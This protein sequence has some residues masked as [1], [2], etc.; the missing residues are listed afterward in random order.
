MLDMLFDPNASDVDIG[1]DDYDDI[2]AK[3]KALENE[4][5]SDMDSDEEDN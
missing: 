1:F 4:P 5:N 2:P 3:N